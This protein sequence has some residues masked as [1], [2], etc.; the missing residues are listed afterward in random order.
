MAVIKLSPLIVDI[1]NSVADTTYSAWKGRNYIRSRVTPANPKT[2]GQV[3][4]RAIMAAAVTNWQALHADLVAAWNSWAAD[5]SIS[6]FNAFTARNTATATP[7]GDGTAARMQISC[8]YY[9]GLMRPTAGGPELA[10]FTAETGSSTGEIDVSWSATGWTANDK[11]YVAAWNQESVVYYQAPDYGPQP[12]AA[13]TGTVTISGLTAGDHYTI[14]A[15]AW[16]ESEDA[17]S[18]VYG[19]KMIAAAS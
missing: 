19:G 14:A 1:R 3:K 10:D 11:V 8:S 7:N 13:D 6:G 16:D 17:W 15:I 2:T 5:Y 18:V 9:P 4:Q 12:T